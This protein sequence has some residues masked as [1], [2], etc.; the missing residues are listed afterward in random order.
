MA[1]SYSP[2]ETVVNMALERSFRS[3]TILD[4]GAVNGH[5][6]IQLMELR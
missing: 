6:R 1:K 2:V 3:R 4:R 5:F